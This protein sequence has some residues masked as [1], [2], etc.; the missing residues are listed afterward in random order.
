MTVAMGADF[1]QVSE[2]EPLDDGQPVFFVEYLR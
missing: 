1:F 2:I